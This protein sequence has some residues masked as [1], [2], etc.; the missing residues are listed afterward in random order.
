MKRFILFILLGIVATMIV[1]STTHARPSHRKYK[2]LP[3]KRYQV[4]QY[5]GAKKLMTE[6]PHV[7]HYQTGCAAR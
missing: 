4:P 3:V 2:R 1:I 7:Y 5:W 6:T